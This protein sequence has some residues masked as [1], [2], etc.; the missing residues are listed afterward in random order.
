MTPAPRLPMP[1]LPLALGLALGLLG[2]L[3]AVDAAGARTRTFCSAE[4]L[5][6]GK[7]IACGGHLDPECTS[8]AACDS[9]HN[10]YSGDPFPKTIDCPK[11]GFVDIPNETVTAGC[12]DR[13]PTCADCGGE[14]QVPCPVEA[15]PICTAGC[16]SGL[17]ENPTTTLCEIPGSPGTPCGPGF[18]CAEGLTCD[19]FEG[20]TCVEKVGAGESCANP[21][22]KC[23]AGL[24][25]TL[26]L[27]CS[28]EPARLGETCDV[29]AP[30]ADGLYCQAGVPQRCRAYRKPG[31]GCS[32]VKPCIDGASCE[33]CLT[34]KCNAPLQCFWNANNGA[35]TE[36]QC[37][38]LYSPGDSQLAQ[39][40]G[41]TFT[42]AAGD[43][44]SGGVAE[45]QAFGFAYGQDGRYGCFTTF[46][47][48]FDVDASVE[49]FVSVGLYE[50]YD[51]VGDPFGGLSFANVQ[52]VQIPGSL[53]NISTSQVYEREGD[54]PDFT[55]G[56]LVG[57]EDAF[58]VGVGAS[59]SP[60]AAGSF[61]C[62]TVLD[63]VRDPFGVDPFPDP[64]PSPPPPDAGG[65][66]VANPDFDVDLAHWSCT[67][68]GVCAW[69]ADD[70]FA[71]T[72]SGSGEVASP[73]AGSPSASGRLESSCV[74]VDEGE[75]YLLSAWAKTSGALPGSLYALWSPTD[76]CGGVA[77]R[78]V[79]GALPPDNAWRRYEAVVE[80]PPGAKSVTLKTTAQR[81]R[82]TGEASFT[83][84]D[85]VY[86]P[87]PGAT[88][89]A[90][91]A[92][93]ALALVA[94]GR[95]LR[96]ARRPG[97][98]PAAAWRPRSGW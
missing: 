51:D 30:C 9:G 38:S 96:R 87:E 46:C 17:T 31:Q 64:D 58:S 27:E 19:P 93:L 48:G 10:R 56:A 40:E 72:V 16:D 18:P 68:G 84:I 3:L 41:L 5:Y 86:V 55:T 89:T 14:G 35:I 81:D 1:R 25:C 49:A 26:A 83:R 92:G 42:Y 57:T 36:Q 91:A 11:I 98:A 43:A 7:S 4:P 32:A 62:E 47:Y 13:R 21:F 67:N 82:D 15:E 45:S 79:L 69:V 66:A 29:S 63:T 8:G 61:L 73:P 54:F 95:A 33:P 59:P 44:L 24:Q 23:A 75:T 80:A 94:L 88:A 2:P 37:K 12:Y 65:S 97:R 71:S 53:A 34:E 74:A 76:G 85:S 90:I 22:E 70:P 52:E 28:H 60:F 20:F 78:D 6:G 39:D 77:G 50:T